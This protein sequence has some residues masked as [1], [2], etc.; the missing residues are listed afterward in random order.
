MTDR[1]RF[2]ELEG[3]VLAA[4]W[5]SPR[6][7][8][9]AEVQAAVGGDLAYTTVMTILVRLYR[10]G[11]IDRTKV[12]RAFA[13]R[14]VV[15]ESEVVADRVR[16]M[17]DHGQDR[18]AVIQGFLAGLSADEEATLRALLDGDADPDAD[19]DGDGRG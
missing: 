6:P 14:P 18:V 10:K 9:P 5:A 8:T 13:Y 7:L 15:A 1:R 3:E 19:R 4:L 17:L 16:R 2:G 12:G 11:A